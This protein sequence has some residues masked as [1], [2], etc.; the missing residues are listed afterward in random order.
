MSGNRNMIY[1]VG[2]AGVLC[3]IVV[4]AAQSADARVY[5]DG[6]DLAGPAANGPLSLGGELDTVTSNEN[7]PESVF[8]EPPIKSETDSATVEPE[9]IEN[10][11]WTDESPAIPEVA[12]IEQRP[13][14]RDPGLLNIGGNSTAAE[15][16]LQA[17]GEGSTSTY[18][19]N[20]FVKVGGALAVVLAL[21]FFA[22]YIMRRMGGSMLRAGRPG[23]VLE[24]LAKYPVGRGQQLVLLKLDRRILLLHQ[25]G[26]SMTTLSEVSDPNEVASLL[27]RIESGSRDGF[28][29]RFQSLLNQTSISAS[30]SNDHSM[31]TVD[32][33]RPTG[34]LTSRRVMI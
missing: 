3:A 8:V 14:G 23:G 33:T 31:Q 19:Q 7:I 28:A 21:I 13:L 16:D 32:L 15:S 30:R 2:L 22:A 24:I 6:N 5:Q 12:A 1:L 27:S 34:L 18:S 25:T 10:D 11:I 17:T 29:Y 4:I 20:E 9:Y 26:S